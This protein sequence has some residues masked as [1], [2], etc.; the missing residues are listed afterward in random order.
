MWASEAA[1]A[2]VTGQDLSEADFDEI[3]NLSV[4][5]L[6]IDDADRCVDGRKL[7][8]AINLCRDRKAPLL[9]SGPPEPA[10]WFDWPGDLR[11]RLPGH[12]RQPPSKSRRM[13]TRSR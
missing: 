12:A 5:A 4:A 8:V 3:G 2:F 9:V 7:M 13:K 6:A 11:S 1:A 10:S